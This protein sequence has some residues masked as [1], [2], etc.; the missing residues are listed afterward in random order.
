MIVDVPNSDELKSTATGWINLSWEIAI[1]ALSEFIQTQ[2]YYDELESGD[3]DKFPI[4]EQVYWHNKRYKMNNAI[5]LLQQSLELFL[6]ARISEVSPYLLIVG[7]WPSPKDGKLSFSEFRTI[8]ASQ[9]CRSASIVSSH[10][11]PHGFR[12]LYDRLRTQRNKIVHLNA[13]N[14]RVEGGNILLDILAAHHFLFPDLRW[15]SVRR[16]F[17]NSDGVISDWEHY[18]DDFTHPSFMY[19]IN[20]ALS[21]LDGKVTKKY[22]GYDKR[23]R[24]L[25]CPDCEGYRT[26]WHEGIDWKFA[27][28]QKDGTIFCI[29]CDNVYTAEEYK[30]RLK[31]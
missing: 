27:Q 26:K 17:M 11:I 9:L 23:K 16:D 22:F 6:K 21:V 14:I 1:Q 18:E 31:G 3:Q 19:E 4:N 15:L 13:G 29:A 25:E 24:S 8:D 7:D 5:S 10:P 30:E 28:K 20:V 12:D 2:D